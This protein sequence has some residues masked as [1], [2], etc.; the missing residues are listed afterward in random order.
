[1]RSDAVGSLSVRQGIVRHDAQVGQRIVNMRYVGKDHRS[2][3]VIDNGEAIDRCGNIHAACYQA[4]KGDRGI[5][6][7][8]RC[9]GGT[10]NKSAST[11]G[12]LEYDRSVLLRCLSNQR[13]A[14]AP[15]W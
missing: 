7:D 12:D 2:R 11:T 9:H 14:R 3:T 6:V 1:M 13:Y 8:I 5:S 4:I 15:G 10:A